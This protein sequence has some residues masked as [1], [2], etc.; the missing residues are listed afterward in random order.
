MKTKNL[1]GILMLFLFTF[2]FI[3]C[4]KED[5]EGRK[6]TDYKEYVLT[7]ASE[8]RPGL[9]LAEGPD[10]LKEVYPVKKENSEEWETLSNIDGF[11]FENGYE[12]RIKIS[13]TSYLDYSMGQ[14]AWTEHELLE[15]ISKEKKASVGLPKHFIPEAFYKDKFLPTYKYAVEADNKEV[16]EEDLKNHSILPL[17]YHYFYYAHSEGPKWLAIKDDISVLG[18]GLIKRTNKTQEEFPEVYQILPPERQVNG[19]ME[20]SF[21]DEEGNETGYPSFDV[22]LGYS[23][24][25]REAGVTSN[26]FYLYKDLTAHYKSKYP[27]AG[28]KAVVVSYA[29][30]IN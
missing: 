20:W 9:M 12:Y 18:P 19:F 26:L 5:E 6:I 27:D 29:I 25:S 21:L 14:P 4:D 7:V 17:D 1:F 8:M 22:F 30:E 2:A 24:R 16:I 15:V 10:F 28:V 11:E 23:A 13:E 3:S